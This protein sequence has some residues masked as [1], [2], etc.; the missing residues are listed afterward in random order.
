MDD[1]T[2]PVEETLHSMILSN[3]ETVIQ[4]GVELLE[5]LVKQKAGLA[6]RVIPAA[7]MTNFLVASSDKRRSQAKLTDCLRLILQ[8]SEENPL[9]D[10]GVSGF[11]TLGNEHEPFF[12]L[13]ASEQY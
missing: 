13:L 11:I 2:S 5:F 4:K 8:Y 10:T 9:D 12:E 7:T 3:S 1:D 6:D